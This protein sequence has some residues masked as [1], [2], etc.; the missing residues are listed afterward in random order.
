MLPLVLRLNSLALPL[1]CCTLQPL[2]AVGIEGAWG[3]VLCFVLLPLLAHFKTPE[4]LPLDDLVAALQQIAGD[5]Q[6]RGAVLLS[7]CSIGI[8]NFFGLSV[9]KALSGAARATI[10]ACRTLFVWLFALAVGWEA[11]HGLQVVGFLVLITGGWGLAGGWQ[12][13]GGG[14]HSVVAAGGLVVGCSVMLVQWCCV[15][16]VDG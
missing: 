10:D 14:H 2:L 9:T 12:Q 16:R 8:F 6:L 4:G 7:I 13:G 1:P 3:V 5:A 11:F 15:C